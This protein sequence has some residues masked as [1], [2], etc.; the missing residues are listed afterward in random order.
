M[1]RID[2]FKH[3][4]GNKELEK[5]F[6]SIGEDLPESEQRD[7]AIELAN[8]YYKIIHDD[9]NVLNTLLKKP[10]V[11]FK[12]KNNLEQIKKVKEEADAKIKALRNQAEGSQKNSGAGD[13]GV[14]FIKKIFDKI[15]SITK[16]NKVQH[17]ILFNIDTKLSKEIADAYEKM[18]HDP[19]NPK[20]KKAYKAMV[21]ETKQQYDALIEGGLKAERW[22][23]KGEPYANS[24]EMLS[25]LKENNHLWFLPNESAFG[26]KDAATKY[27]DN[28]GLQDSGITL[29]GKPLTNSEVF[30]IVHDAVHGINGNEFGAIGEENAT[31]Q[32]LSMYSDEALPA[33]VAQT[34]GQNSWVNFSGVNDSANAKFKEAAKLE[35]EG[36]YDEAKKIRKEAQKEFIFAEP[37]IGLLPNKYNFR[38]YGTKNSE[39]ASKEGTNTR[40]GDGNKGESQPI[41]A[42]TDEKNLARESKSFSSRS[43]NRGR[44]IRTSYGDV[45]P[46]AIHT[47]KQSLIDGINKVF[48][49]VAIDKELFEVDAD[50]FHKAAI[51]AK[52]VNKYGAA[53]DILSP[54][55][56]SNYRLFITEDGLTGIALSPTGDLG[57][58]FDMSGKSRRLVQLLVLGIENGAT[59]ANAFDTILPDYYSAF[60]FKPVARNLWNDALKP[61]DWNY[62]TFEKWNKGRPDVVH[63]VWDGGDRNN[64]HERIGQF[65]NYSDYHK[66]QTPVINTWEEAQEIVQQSIPTQEVKADV[67]SY[68]GM[69]NPKKTGI[70]GLDDLLKDDGYNY[71]YK[72]VSGEIVM[73]SPDEYLKKVRDDITRS[74]SDLN[75]YDE[76]KASII[77]GVN[78]G[79]KINMPY[80]SIKENGK[81]HK[82]EGRNRAVVAR[83]RGE[84]LI[85]VFIEKDIS[86]DDKIK[87]GNEYVKSAVESGA[88][89]KEEVLSKLKEQGLHRDAVRFISENFN[90]ELLPTQ[91]NKT[92]NT[93]NEKGK[94]EVETSNVGTKVR[95]GKVEP[96]SS[97]TESPKA[98]GKQL[99]N[100][101]SNRLK[102]ANM[103]EL[104]GTN[105]YDM[106][107]QAITSFRFSGNVLQEILGRKESVVRK[108]KNIKEEATQRLNWTRGWKN[109]TSR[110]DSVGKLSE[111]V[112]ETLSDTDREIYDS[113]DV[114]NVIE[115]V[116]I[117][118]TSF[119]KIATYL[120]DKYLDGDI[121]STIDETLEKRQQQA[122]EDYYGIPDGWDAEKEDWIDERYKKAHEGL[123]G[124]IDLLTDEDFESILKDSEAYFNS[125]EYKS[126][127]GNVQFMASSN[128]PAIEKASKEYESAKRAFDN[129]RKEL[130]GSAMSDNADLFGNVRSQENSLFGD[131]TEKAS[132][133][134]I[135]KALA[136][137]KVRLDN[138]KKALEKAN[139]DSQSQGTLFS[140]KKENDTSSKSLA[141]TLKKLIAT[142]KKSI[143][144]NV[145]SDQEL[146]KKKLKEYGIDYTNFMIIGK[147]GAI[148]LDNAEMVLA[149]LSLSK[150]LNANIS[151]HTSV[152]SLTSAN[153]YVE[154]KAGDVEAAFNVVNAKYKNGVSDILKQNKD[155]IIVSVHGIE[156]TGQNALPNALAEAVSN[157]YGNPIDTSIVLSNKPNH[158]GAKAIV[159]LINVPTFSGEVI[160]GRKYFI[161]DDVSATGSTAQALRV[162]IESN[163]GR[164]IGA[165]FLATTVG[166]GYLQIKDLQIS[167]L[168]AKFGRQELEKT[169]T[170]YGIANK[171]E[172]LSTEQARYVEGFG[173]LIGFR[174]KIRQGYEEEA[175]RI[176]EGVKTIER[177]KSKVGEPK[178]MRTPNGVIYGA[179]FPDGSIYINE[180]NIDLSS[181]IHEF[182][183][184]FEEMFPELWAEGLRLFRD[185]SGFKKAL[186]EV[187]KNPSYKNLSEPKQAS[188]ALNNLIGNKGVGYFAKGVLLSK[189]QNWVKKLFKTIGAKISSK[190]G[191]KL[192]KRFA[193]TPDDKLEFFVNDV[194]GKLLSGKELKGETKIS[195]I[196]KFSQEYENSPQFEK[197]KGKNRLVSDRAVQDVK[198]GEPIVAKVYH[199]TTNEFYEFD[200][201]VKGNIEG[202]LGKVNYFTTSEEDANEN[203][204]ASGSDITSRI[205]RESE[206][207]EDYLYDEYGIVARQ[208]P[209][210]KIT[211]E[212]YQKISEEFNISVKEL[213]EQKTSQLYK[214]IAERQLKG[215][216]EKVL[217]LYVKL[218]N[219][220][221]LGN[222]STWF[223]ALEIDETY[224]EEA[225]QEVAEEYGISEQEAKDE[226]DWDIRDRAIEKQGE[227]NKVVEALE[228]ALSDNGYDSSLA[229]Q[230][231]GDNYYETEVD[232]DNI[233]K[234]LRKAELY[235]NDNGEMASSQVIADLFKNL[236][237]DGIILTDV[238]ERFKNMGLN[239]STS[240]IHVFDEFSNQ[241]KLADGT[242]TTFNPDTN[243]IRYMSINGKQVQVKALGADVV[244]GFYSPLEKVINETKFDK[245]PAKQWIEKFAK[246]EEAKWTGLNEWLSNQQ[247]SVSKSDIQQYLKDNRISVVEVVKGETKPKELRRFDEIIDTLKSRGYEVDVEDY[248][249][250]DMNVIGYDD[251]T[252]FLEAKNGGFTNEELIR[253]GYTL[254]ETH[255]ED[256]KLLEE[257]QKLASKIRDLQQKED[258]I[259]GTKF[260]QYQLEGEKENYAEKLVILPNK[261]VNIS[262]F[263]DTNADYIIEAY[264]KS[265]KLVVEC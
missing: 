23:G 100:N 54:K 76:K 183:H 173:S 210:V 226:Y 75:I 155:A 239:N 174:N 154:A 132:E 211:D 109:Q 156:A 3:I 138:A 160:K 20:V 229:S 257:A 118:F 233:E 135:Q 258:K 98:K 251:G 99:T 8:K 103:L 165:N 200:A 256:V 212:D 110:I 191:D 121:N 101:E 48:P 47:V 10:R 19:N 2:C 66:E 161:V 16:L 249:S 91:E 72:G 89:T 70:S 127:L 208:S 168:V 39:I 149:D 59:H 84:K 58:G 111:M 117:D 222:G 126:T 79:D 131:Q 36:K 175:N 51:K 148:G 172:H 187:Q 218:N 102:V 64:I 213:K 65:D 169:L 170:Q 180:E 201:S 157:E 189:F 220:I 178:L 244:N 90:N 195:N 73:M 13:K 21:E 28:I 150:L 217:D 176:I 221:V 137:F 144:A 196:T 254:K 171:I 105:L 225:T 80:L 57:S 198:T 237:F 60:G 152:S 247:G 243:D 253:D 231:L 119:G 209:P 262:E 86:F 45:V 82:Q 205:S 264:K 158:T 25:D 95:E 81:A 194:L 43:N 192:A 236:G 85:P 18:K 224:L 181:P 107:A 30:R 185:S 129:K 62:T 250:S 69:F 108:R 67:E 5:H 151:R 63:F 106:V 7:K 214:F 17:N 116:I 215:N 61:K 24:K 125:D 240:H 145:F 177:Q 265:G 33:V 143:K 77:E 41:N 96:S 142:L 241:I 4:K 26:D 31:L 6:S 193:L 136:P 228:K 203:Y 49:N 35:K 164:V 11:V 53:V 50:I 14:P 153:G 263:V 93:K 52:S 128:N 123:L 184:L 83:E 1:P 261:E 166:G 12:P 259:Q 27:K 97:K 159:R 124:A 104:H 115:S 167:S 68:E 71:F 238:S 219:P 232:L 197:W 207:L 260:S 134:N 9:M 188:E 130:Y 114:L 133:E 32:H 163:G 74:S 146:L 139:K 199:G 44:T 29:D 190:L 235:E 179:K 87:K 216:E 227:G 242:N 248:A 94:N 140:A 147:K 22:T 182:S 246:G 46:K 38:Y 186:A 245:L 78:K 37:K 120:I 55:E 255:D 113:Q 206:R 42:L 141:T 122:Y 230:I 234:S 252:T 92:K 204:L 223:D 202:H 162:Y 34:R 15:R 40:S 112:L 56:Y 88:N